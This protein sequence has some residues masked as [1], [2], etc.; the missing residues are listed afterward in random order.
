[1]GAHRQSFGVTLN[2]FPVPFGVV[3]KSVLVG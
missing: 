3:E 2:I 1:M